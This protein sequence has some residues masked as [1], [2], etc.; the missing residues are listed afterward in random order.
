MDREAPKERGP[1]AQLHKLGRRWQ[2]TH[3][4]MPE[5][6]LPLP[7]PA[8]AAA[9]AGAKVRS[10]RRRAHCASP[11]WPGP[12]LPTPFLPPHLPR[13]S[14]QPP[15]NPR[16]KERKEREKHAP[17]GSNRRETPRGKTNLGPG[18]WEKWGAAAGRASPVPLALREPPSRHR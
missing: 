14:R 9:A 1:R 18:L 12:T 2:L 16:K 8:A 13:H 5:A 4:Q 17:R 10:A 3:T 7:G 11:P 6:P 15:G